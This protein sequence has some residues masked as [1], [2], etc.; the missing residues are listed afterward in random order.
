[1]V[2][3]TGFVVCLRVNAVR[4]SQEDE[5][6][7]VDPAQRAFVS[8]DVGSGLA[9]AFNITSPYIV[10]GGPPVLAVGVVTDSLQQKHL[11][12]LHGHG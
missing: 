3:L 12:V 4:G 10:P 6:V 9:R 8:R 5:V 1:V 2:V 7:V 11:S